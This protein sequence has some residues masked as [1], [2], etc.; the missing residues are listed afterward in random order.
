MTNSRISVLAVLL[1]FSAALAA[2]SGAENAGNTNVAVTNEGKQNVSVTNEAKG[3][4]SATNESNANLTARNEYPDNVVEEFLRSCVAAGSERSFC[5]CVLDK[6]QDKYTF[7]EFSV[8]E[9]KIN[10]GQA[11][12]EFVEFTGMARAECSK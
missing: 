7:E 3:D 12:E 9:S 11:P 5:R 1:M 4:V 10:A 8:I 2:C 6:V